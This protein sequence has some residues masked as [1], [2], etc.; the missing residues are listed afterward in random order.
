MAVAVSVAFI[1]GALFKLHYPD[2]SFVFKA[3]DRFADGFNTIRY[4][5][6]GNPYANP[7]MVY[8]PFTNVVVWPFTLPDKNGGVLCLLAV[9]IAVTVVLML[10]GT[11]RLTSWSAR[12][13]A[14]AVLL[15]SYPIVFTVDRANVEILVYFFIAAF[16][17]AMA[18]RRPAI[19]AVA[20]SGAIAMKLT[21]LVFAG[22]FLKKGLRRW[23][24]LIAG[25]VA[26]ETFMGLVMLRPSISTSIT[27]LKKALSYYNRV[28]VDG[29]AG[30]HFGSS[31]LGGAKGIV[32]LFAGKPGR[33]SFGHTFGPVATGVSILGLAAVAVLIGL[34]SRPL[35]W[36]LTVATLSLLLLTPVSADYRLIHLFVPLAV[37]L[38]DRDAIP[39]ERLIAIG[40]GFLLVPKTFDWS[41]GNAWRDFGITVSNIANAGLLIALLVVVLLCKPTN[42][43]AE[44][45]P[46][47]AEALDASAPDPVGVGG[48]SQ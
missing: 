43:T 23:L 29:D 1:N 45:P 10:W 20:I 8:F 15:A 35:W 48:A 19:A 44:H 7:N 21:P 5:H 24:G 33:I 39:R 42:T 38:A 31:L 26:V 37:F 36:K 32:T 13:T 2:N 28:F 34:I 12:L 41:F 14:T 3:S 22:V 47:G 17:V 4:V 11:R 40:F 30:Y 25:F 6:S 16:G 27:E 9:L 18:V 46:S